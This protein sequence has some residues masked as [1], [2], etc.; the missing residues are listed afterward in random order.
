MDHFDIWRLSVVILMKVDAHWSVYF[1]LFFLRGMGG[2]DGGI[3]FYSG[4]FLFLAMDDLDGM[5]GCSFLD[6]EMYYG[7]NMKVGQLLLLATG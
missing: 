2:T 5:M 1:S 6:V 4:V 7:M 3:C